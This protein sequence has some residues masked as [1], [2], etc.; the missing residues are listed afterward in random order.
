M[1]FLCSQFKNVHLKIKCCDICPYRS[2]KPKI[3]SDDEHEAETELVSPVPHIE[4]EDDDDGVIKIRQE[5]DINAM[6]LPD[7]EDDEDNGAAED[8]LYNLES[9]HDEDG[10]Y[11]QTDYKSTNHVQKYERNGHDD[12]EEQLTEDGVDFENQGSVEQGFNGVEYEDDEIEGSTNH[13]LKSERFVHDEDEYEQEEEEDYDED[14]EVVNW[15]NGEEGELEMNGEMDDDG[16]V[17]EDEGDYEEMGE[18]EGDEGLNVMYANGNNQPPGILNYGY[19]CKYCEKFFTTR[20][21]VESHEQHHKNQMS[22]HVRRSNEPRRFPCKICKD[23][24]FTSFKDLKMHVKNHT[25]ERIHICKF[26]FSTFNNTASLTKHL[27]IHTRENPH[28]CHCGKTFV[29]ANT[30]KIHKKIHTGVKPFVCNFFQCGRAFVTKSTL[31]S[32]LRTHTGEKPYQCSFCPSSFTTSSAK[33]RHE[34]HV[35]KVPEPT[36]T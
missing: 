31:E 29:S 3:N 5:V 21:G 18:D 8:T 36:I 26:C 13:N 12:D 2:P 25:P 9:G 20:R 19:S 22:P 35:H 11:E 4:D 32:H 10:A 24:S 17:Y 34:R 23:K 16:L 7:E 27:I 28:K 14:G 6:V 1:S 33:Y 15:G 30:L